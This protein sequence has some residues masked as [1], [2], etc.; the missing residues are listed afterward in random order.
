MRPSAGQL[1]CLL[2][3]KHEE[4]GAQV[5]SSFYPPLK[6]NLKFHLRVTLKKMFC[7]YFTKWIINKLG[8]MTGSW[9]LEEQ[10]QLGRE[11]KCYF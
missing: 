3:Y 1:G 2:L 7:Y 5:L 10:L 6:K 11:Y 9:S 4:K 8:K